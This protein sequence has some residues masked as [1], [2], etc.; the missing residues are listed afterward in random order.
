MIIKVQD[1]KKLSLDVIYKMYEATK[2]S[3]GSTTLTCDPVG[4]SV[5]A[6]DEGIKIDFGDA[7][8]FSEALH[9]IQRNITE[10]PVRRF[11]GWDSYDGIGTWFNP[12]D[13]KV[14]IDPIYVVSSRN[15]AFTMAR[16]LGELA[17]FEFESGI[18]HTVDY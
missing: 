14:Y 8:L 5:G 6:G 10:D 1:L 3:G 4:F 17:I 18:V 15:A 13:G 7:N 2:K 9:K 12:D 16:L 11:Q